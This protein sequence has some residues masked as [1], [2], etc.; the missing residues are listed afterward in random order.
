MAQRA[1]RELGTQFR[2]QP[3]LSCP[4][5]LPSCFKK[6][7]DFGFFRIV[8]DTVIKKLTDIKQKGN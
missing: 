5:T 7:H 4:T 1:V 6:P 8:R 3:S 2:N